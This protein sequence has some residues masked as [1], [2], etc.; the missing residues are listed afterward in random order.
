VRGSEETISAKTSLK[1]TG[2]L[3]PFFFITLSQYSCVYSL[4]EMLG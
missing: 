3:V 2:R 1:G 4:N